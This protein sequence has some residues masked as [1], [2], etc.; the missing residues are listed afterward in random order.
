MTAVV[1]HVNDEQRSPR[2]H[3]AQLT[4]ELA[5]GQCVNRVTCLTHISAVRAWSVPSVSDQGTT[6]S[7][8]RGYLDNGGSCERRAAQEDELYRRGRPRESDAH[9]SEACAGQRGAAEHRELAVLHP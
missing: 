5:I 6:W 3:E 2:W 4:T 8:S 7:K 1:L 9:I